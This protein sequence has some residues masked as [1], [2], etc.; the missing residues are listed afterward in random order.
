MNQNDRLQARFTVRPL[1]AGAL[2]P[3]MVWAVVPAA[4]QTA[5]ET[6]SRGRDGRDRAELDVL[7]AQQH[8]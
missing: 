6:S 7:D 2:A 4:A 5:L 1:R 3:L 8:V